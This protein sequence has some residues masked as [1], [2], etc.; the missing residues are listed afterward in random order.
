MWFCHFRFS[1][2]LLWEKCV[3]S[4][5]THGG[6]YCQNLSHMRSP[7]PKKI[8]SWKFVYY[9][10]FFPVPHCFSQFFTVFHCMK[11]GCCWNSI[12]LCA[13]AAKLLRNATFWK[14]VCRSLL[15]SVRPAL[16]RETHCCFGV[17]NPTNLSL[18]LSDRVYGV[19][20]SSAD[21]RP[22]NGGQ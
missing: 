7:V 12:S 9:C 4:C 22:K 16:V 20:P 17:H 6:L 11:F 3:I 21:H 18:S 13:F 8:A 2:H 15:C 19:S 1:V 5:S 10:C 14:F